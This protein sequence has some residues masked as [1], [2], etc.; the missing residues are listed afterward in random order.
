MGNTGYVDWHRLTRTQQPWTASAAGHT[1]VFVFFPVDYG[2]NNRDHGVSLLKNEG[3]HPDW[4]VH[5]ERGDQ[6]LDAYCQPDTMV[7]P[8][9]QAIFSDDHASKPLLAGI[10]LGTSDREY[11]SN[12][13]RWHCTKSHLTRAGKKL[14]KELTGLY[15]REPAII[16]FVD[17][18]TD[19][20]SGP[21]DP[22]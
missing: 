12:E 9:Y 1:S 16:T 11:I 7:S 2:R 8:N 15:L 20:D 6:V 21:R 19:E 4:F 22:S 3:L 18:V 5:A 13:Y 17:K 10:L 14:I